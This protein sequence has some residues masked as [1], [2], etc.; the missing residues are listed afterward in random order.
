MSSAS[1]HSC[2]VIGLHFKQN[3]QCFDPLAVTKGGI[4]G[5][6]KGKKRIFFGKAGTLWVKVL[7]G[8]GTLQGMTWGRHSVSACFS[9]KCFLCDE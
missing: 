4:S 7:L 8:G 1:D 9:S 3:F 6:E 2:K 5:P